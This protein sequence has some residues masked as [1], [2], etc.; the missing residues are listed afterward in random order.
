MRTDA[1]STKACVV[2]AQFETADQQ[3]V[4]AKLGIWVFLASEIM[5]FGAPLFGY[6]VYR[7]KY[8]SA[9]AEASTHLG[10][11]LGTINTSILL[12]SSLTMALSIDAIK[13]ERRG[14]VLFLFATMGLGATFLG[15]KGWEYYEKWRDHLVP[16]P[17]FRWLGIEA[18]G[19]V[20]LFFSFYFT[21]TACHA[22]HMGIGLI[23]MAI[24][25]YQT[26]G[27]RFSAKY[28]TPIELLGLYWHFVDCVWVLL[29][30]LLYLVNRN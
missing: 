25:T 18:T 24:F 13:R 6:T 12:T 15:I 29:F 11:L 1:P 2:A 21:L 27:A 14:A 7:S 23:L 5:F 22:L 4:A 17:E 30:P 9:W 28:H 10:L 26:Y 8:S 19:P 20:E 16:G 3:S